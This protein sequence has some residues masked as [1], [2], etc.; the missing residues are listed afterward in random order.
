[1]TEPIWINLRVIK[2]FHDRQINENMVGY[3]GYVTRGYCYQPCRGP[4]MPTTTLTQNL[5]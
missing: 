2:A 5:T 4:K 3:Q 1:M